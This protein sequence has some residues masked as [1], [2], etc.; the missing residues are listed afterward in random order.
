MRVR[1][2][3]LVFLLLGA[4]FIITDHN[5]HLNKGNEM[6]KFIGFYYSWFAG[7]F[8]NVKG[9]TGYVIRSE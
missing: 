1:V 2:L 5:I 8:D 6:N 4:F 9:V 7:L 3:I